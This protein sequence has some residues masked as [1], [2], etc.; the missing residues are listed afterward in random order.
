MRSPSE[1]KQ[2]GAESFTTGLTDGSIEKLLTD[3][4]SSDEQ[5]EHCEQELNTT[6]KRKRSEASVTVEKHCEAP[7][8]KRQRTNTVPT[9]AQ[10]TTALPKEVPSS[11]ESTLS[12]A[13]ALISTQ[14]LQDD[15]APKFLS[16]K[17][18]QQSWRKNEQHLQTLAI[19]LEAYSDC[20]MPI[21]DKFVTFW[22]FD[23]EKNIFTKALQ[24]ARCIAFV[25]AIRSPQ[26]NLNKVQSWID[27]NTPLVGKYAMYL[28]IL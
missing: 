9:G 12:T 23:C 15:S 16:E 5:S 27:G 3:T 13:D 26:V 1:V 14:L 7:S 10:K 11:N 4:K 18:I 25:N 22:S 19:T 6:Q 17:M 21:F 24:P 20:L 2:T 28:N 8:S